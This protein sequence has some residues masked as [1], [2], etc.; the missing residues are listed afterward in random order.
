MFWMSQSLMS[1]S[2]MLNISDLEICVKHVENLRPLVLCHLRWISQTQS[3]CHMFWISQI[4]D[5]CHMLEYLRHP[6]LCWWCW[7]S[8]TMSSVCCV[9]NISDLAVCASCLN[10]SGQESVSLLTVKIS[11][12]LFCVRHAGYLKLQGLCHA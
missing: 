12:L 2:Y 5:L 10:I 11:D 7:I 3:L 9:L 4:L 1:V 6:V 8:Q